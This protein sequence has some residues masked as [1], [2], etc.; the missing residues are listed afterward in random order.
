MSQGTIRNIIQKAEKK[1]QPAIAFIKEYIS[2][3]PVVGFNESGCYC[4]KRLD[5]SWIAQTVYCTLVF[6]ANVDN[7][8]YAGSSSNLMQSF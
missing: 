4:N 6:C 1:A 3:S 7:L 8:E 2:H 5:W